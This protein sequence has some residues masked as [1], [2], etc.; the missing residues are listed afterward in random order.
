MKALFALLLLPVISGGLLAV[1]FR[2]ITSAGE[3]QI[4]RLVAGNLLVLGFL[5][6]IV[7]AGGEV[8]YRYLHDTTEALSLSRTTKLWYQHHWLHNS[9][10]VRDNVEYARAIEPGKRRVTFIGDSFTAGHG[11][12]NIDDRFANLIRRDHPDWEVHLIA[13]S[14]WDTGDH[15]REL[16]A[17]LDKGEQLDEV[18][19][20]YCLNDIEDILPE[21]VAAVKRLQAERGSWLERSFFYSAM[22]ARMALWREP[23]LRNHWVAVLNGYNSASVWPQ[24]AARLDSLRREVEHHGGRLSV[25]LFPYLHRLGRDYEYWSAHR[26]LGAFWQQRGVRTLDLLDVFNDLPSSKV[27]VNRFDAH[28]NEFAHALAARAIDRFLRQQMAA[29]T[30]ASR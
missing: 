12:K 1:W 16:A 9:D 28:P 24:Q 23:D 10:G 20:V 15:L 2:R 4:L 25:V 29:A 3:H 14:G 13:E 27:V 8:Y 26:Q 22:H 21:F 5:V 19:L 17:R 11:V 18:V 7:V 6:S 30:S